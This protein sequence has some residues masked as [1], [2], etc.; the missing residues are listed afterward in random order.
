MPDS[1]RSS[2]I[3]APDYVLFD[4][5]CVDEYASEPVLDLSTFFVGELPDAVAH[6]HQPKK[7]HGLVERVGLPQRLSH[8]TP[9]IAVH[10]MGNASDGTRLKT[11]KTRVLRG[12]SGQ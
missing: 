11:P 8:Q 2:E 9:F 4:T 5:D 10:T 12:S 6:L 1:N 3:E 7:A